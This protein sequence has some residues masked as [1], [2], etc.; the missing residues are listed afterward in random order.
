MDVVVLLSG[1]L[2][3]AANL[4]LAY[5]EGL[6]GHALTVNYGQRAFRQEVVAA[7]KIANYYGYSHSVLDATWLGHLG[8]SSLTD[9]TIRMPSPSFQ[10]L[11]QREMSLKTAKTVWVPNR[12]GL[13]IHMAACLAEVHSCSKILVGFNAEEAATFPDNTVQFIQAVNASLV[14]STANQVVVESYTQCD[15]KRSMVAKLKALKRKVFPF[16]WVWSCYENG[17][18]PCGQCES[19]K[20]F[21]RALATV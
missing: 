12:N 10:D 15:D 20:R 6:G 19:C 3:S 9:S 16:E 4:A 13:L 8:G 17:D 11:D 21:E 7:Q 2:D 14:F 18:R 5:E 1:G